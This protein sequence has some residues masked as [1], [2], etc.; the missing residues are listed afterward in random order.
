METRF[1]S[2]IG[3]IKHN[4]YQWVVRRLHPLF[5]PFI[6]SMV[7]YN[8]MIALLDTILGFLLDLYMTLKEETV[9]W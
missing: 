4:G 9:W 7:A 1:L 3:L 2:K 6:I 8:F 5:I